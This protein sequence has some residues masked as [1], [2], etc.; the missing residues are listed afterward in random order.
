MPGCASSVG[1]FSLAWRRHLFWIGVYILVVLVEVG[2][3]PPGAAAY[4][5]FYLHTWT[6]L[7]EN[8]V[9]HDCAIEEEEEDALHVLTDYLCG[10][11]TRRVRNTFPYYVLW[12]TPPV[13]FPWWDLSYPRGKEGISVFSS[14]IC[15]RVCVLEPSEDLLNLHD[16]GQ[17]P[18]RHGESF[19]PRPSTH[20][21]LAST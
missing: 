20:H 4:P 7:E 1:F 2:G 5:L 10:E 17:H 9:R 11:R 8:D 19:Y 3:G 6:V 14:C 18:S 16:D 13:C 15:A 12:T 21:Q